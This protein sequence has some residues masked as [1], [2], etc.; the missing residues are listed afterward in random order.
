MRCRTTNHSIATSCSWIYS[1]E[2]MGWSFFGFEQLLNP[3]I[4]QRPDPPRHLPTASSPTEINADFELIASP[5]YP[6]L[7]CHRLLGSSSSGQISWLHPGFGMLLL[8]RRAFPSSATHSCGRVP[9]HVCIMCLLES[10]EGRESKS[11][12][13]TPVPSTLVAQSH[14]G[15]ILPFKN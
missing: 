9:P 2:V 7:Q 1:I 8:D 5:C 4:H 10:W 6:M 3:T 12:R 11:L 13:L 15:R 14:F